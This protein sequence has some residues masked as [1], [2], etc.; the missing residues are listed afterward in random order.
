MPYKGEG[1][2]AVFNN[3]KASGKKVLKK[4]GDSNLDDLIDKLLETN[5]EKRISWKDY[6]EHKF[7]KS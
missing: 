3:I 7:F 1:I 4:T 2:I 5:P 6:F